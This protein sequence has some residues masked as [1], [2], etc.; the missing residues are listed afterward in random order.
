MAK[1]YKSFLEKSNIK[2]K[3]FKAY[4]IILYTYKFYKIQ[5]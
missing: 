4:Q 2:Y 5:F 1:V 3:K